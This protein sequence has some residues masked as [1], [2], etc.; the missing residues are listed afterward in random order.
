[1]IL[2][3]KIRNFKKFFFC[4]RALDFRQLGN[5]TPA[6]VQRLRLRKNSRAVKKSRVAEDWSWE[7][8]SFR[9]LLPSVESDVFSYSEKTHGQNLSKSVPKRV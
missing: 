4:V 6:R 9:V 7:F 5:C 8:A 1:M 3:R 2:S